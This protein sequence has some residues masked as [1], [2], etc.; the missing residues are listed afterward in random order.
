MGKMYFYD[1]MYLYKA[2]E[3]FVENENKRQEEEREEYES[4]Y[5]AES[6]RNNAMNNFKMP[7]IN[8]I[9]RNMTSGI[10]NFNIPKI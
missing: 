3:K 8:S 5:N 6:M 9:S 2:Y 1:I 4:S 10:N 7:D